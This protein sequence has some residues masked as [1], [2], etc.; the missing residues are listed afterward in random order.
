MR[1]STAR[2][3]SCRPTMRR[4]CRR[5]S[6]AT[7]IWDCA[8]GFPGVETSMRL[9]LTEV[10]R[11]RLTLPRLCPD[12][13]RHAGQGV[14]P[15]SAQGRARRRR[16]CRHR[17]GRHEPARHDQPRT[18]C[19]RSATPRRSRAFPSLEPRFVRW[20][21]GARSRS[22]V[23]RSRLRDGDET[24]R[25]RDKA[26]FALGS[27]VWTGLGPV[28]KHSSMAR[29]SH[30]RAPDFG[31]LLPACGACRGLRLSARRRRA[32]CLSAQVLRVY[33]KSISNPFRPYR[34]RP[35]RPDPSAAAP[36]RPS[37]RW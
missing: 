37:P 20:S 12:G 27:F 4:I 7:S 5:R 14:R 2:S 11:G 28:R 13:L 3:T 8:P 34:P 9:M 17:A 24:W 6:G 29:V 21:G 18:R 16:R 19:I 10:S 36:R 26:R 32:F 25:P 33:P 31:E 30:P 15:L 35:A 23:P 22:T 1:C